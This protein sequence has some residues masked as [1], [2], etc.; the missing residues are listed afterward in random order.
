MTD[1]K[2][3]ILKAVTSWVGQQ[4]VGFSSDSSSGSL[5]FLLWVGIGLLVGLTWCGAPASVA[6]NVESQ[7]TGTAVLSPA[8]PLLCVPEGLCSLF[9][10]TW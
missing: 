1:V 7:E 5:V 6:A 10:V 9:W 2:V 8:A 3:F 4:G